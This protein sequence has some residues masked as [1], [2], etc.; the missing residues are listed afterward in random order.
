MNE[1]ATLSEYLRLSLP[2]RTED[3]PREK[4]LTMVMDQGWPTDFVAG[5][6]EQFGRY[7][8]IVKLWDP[9]LLSPIA[10]V[11]KKV[12]GTGATT[13]MSSRAACSW[14]SPRSRA[15]TGTL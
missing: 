13:S 15:K 3:K 8:D 1:H 10:A 14:R 12:G 5:M 11:R 6:L 2:S 4:G 9:Q 7:L